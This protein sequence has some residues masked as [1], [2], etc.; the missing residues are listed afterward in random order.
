MFE[1]RGETW[2]QRLTL[3][4]KRAIPL[5]H[6]HM[7]SVTMTVT[8]KYVTSIRYIDTIRE[9]SYRICAYTSLKLAIIIEYHNTMTLQQKRENSK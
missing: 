5:E 3:T 2:F 1:A 8:N 7:E 6:S 9:V 4:N